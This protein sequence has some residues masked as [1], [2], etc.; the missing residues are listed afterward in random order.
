MK[1]IMNIGLLGNYLSKNESSVPLFLTLFLGGYLLC[2]IIPYLLGSMNFGILISKLFYKDDIRNFGSKNAGMTNML[3]TYGKSAAALTLLGDA[4][5]AVLAVYFGRLI[6]G[7]DGGYTAGFFCITGHAFPIYYRFKG[8]KGVVTA[9]AMI[10]VLNPF[11][12]LILLVIFLLLVMATKFISLGSV[13]CIMLYPILLNRVTGPNFS[14]IIAILIMLLVVFLHRSNIK[15]L[16]NGT[17]SKVSFKKE[18]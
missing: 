10:A 6:F 18:K 17:E 14:N 1:E 16:L 11:V 12:F 8:G 2:I 9:A 13:I 7:I 4:L 5:K 3:R 15:R